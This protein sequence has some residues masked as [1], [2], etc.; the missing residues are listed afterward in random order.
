MKRISFIIIGLLILSAAAFA[1]PGGVIGVVLN[2][3]GMGLPRVDVCLTG[4]NGGHGHHDMLH[5]MT[6]PTGNFGF[7]QVQAGAYMIT[8]QLP[9]R[10][11]ASQLIEV[12]ANQTTNVTLTLTAPLPPD[13]DGHGHHGQRDSLVV[14]E[15]TGTAVV[16][17]PDS[18]HPNFMRYGL[19]VNNDGVIDY[20]LSFGPAWYEPTNGAHRPN[21][22]DQITVTGGLFTYTTPPEVIV[23]TINGLPWR[24]PRNGGHGGHGGGDH[25][26]RG[27]EPDSIVRVEFEGTAMV[28]MIGGFHG[29]RVRFMCNTDEDTLAEVVLDFGRP[30]YVP[31]SGATRPLNGDHITIV[32]GQIY[33]ADTVAPRLP[34]VLVYEI[35]GLIWREPGDTVGLGAMPTSIT[36]PIRIADPVSYLTARNYPN[37]FNPTTMINYSIP[38]AGTVKVNVFDITGREVTTLV[39]SYQAAGEYA[40]QWDAARQPSGIYFYRVN[41]GN[42][43]KTFRMVLMK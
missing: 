28:R 10:G 37:P 12:V 27:C 18:L 20:R 2:Q 25:Y 17:Q 6:D 5:I 8:A 24:D 14:V 9:M 41:V 43:S 34:I 40:V 13:S 21:P 22:G 4:V 32:G 30:D 26:R 33:C 16:V 31:P 29:E 42:L 19:D 35:N 38:T 23:F 36:E 11:M 7:R 3:D 1:Q 39:N 15:L